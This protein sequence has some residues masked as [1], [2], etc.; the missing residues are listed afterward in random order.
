MK[1][2]VAPDLTAGWIK[3]GRRKFYYR[4]NTQLFFTERQGFRKYIKIGKLI[5]GTEKR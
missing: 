1:I 5:V 4:W 2:C 3:L